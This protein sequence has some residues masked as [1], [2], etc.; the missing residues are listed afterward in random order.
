MYVLYYYVY[1]YFHVS[2]IVPEI[3]ISRIRK[4]NRKYK[5][6]FCST[7]FSRK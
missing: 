7:S 3:R 1:K 4:I 6:K 5:K 2:E